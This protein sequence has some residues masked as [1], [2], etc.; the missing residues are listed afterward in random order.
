M[1]E[2]EAAHLVTV[3]GKFRLFPSHQAICDAGIIPAARLNNRKMRLI[4]Q[5]RFE[6]PVLSQKKLDDLARRPRLRLPLYEKSPGDEGHNQNGGNTYETEQPVRECPGP[7]RHDVLRLMPLLVNGLNR[8]CFLGTNL[9]L[10]DIHKTTQP[11]PAL[12]AGNQ[13]N[14]AGSFNC[15]VEAAFEVFDQGVFSQALAMIPT[16]HGF[17]LLLEKD[18]ICRS[19]HAKIFME[20]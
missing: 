6:R 3:C 11:H 9:F 2:V 19:Q 1:K 18:V 12:V 16:V 15:G 4:G 5:T 7:P 10:K 20:I 17:A 14:L 13:M 8:T